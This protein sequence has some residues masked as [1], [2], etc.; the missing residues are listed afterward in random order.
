MTPE[1]L[2]ENNKWEC[3]QCNQKVQA[4]KTLEYKQLPKSLVVHLKR[5]R[6]DPITRRRRKL[7]TNVDIPD[8][9][10]FIQVPLW[11]VI[12]EHS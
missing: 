9:F 1:T 11:E 5:T 7:T 8:D 10:P 6:F 3:N 2:D 12:I 4:L